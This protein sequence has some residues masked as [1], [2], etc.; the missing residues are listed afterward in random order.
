MG[1]IRS[2]FG[3]DGLSAFVWHDVALV[4]DAAIEDFHDD[5]GKAIH[6]KMLIS[7]IKKGALPK[8]LQGCSA[9][10]IAMLEWLSKL[11]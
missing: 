11:M 9:S 2:C 4:A 7:T 6:P 8:D 3:Q 10:M 1:G 5:Q